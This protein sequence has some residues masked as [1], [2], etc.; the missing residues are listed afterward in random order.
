M[1]EDKHLNLAL[2]EKLCQ[3]LIIENV[4]IFISD[5]IDTNFEAN[6][7]LFKYFGSY[8]TAYYQ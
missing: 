3:K 6:E 5:G 8:Q 4:Q 2:D 1:N 7:N